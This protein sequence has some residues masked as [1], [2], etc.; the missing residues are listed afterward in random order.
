MMRSTLGAPLG[1]TI[2]GGHQGLESLA[3]FLMMPP[4]FGAGAGSW[5]PGIVVVALAVPSSPVTC[6]AFAEA[7]ASTNAAT[8][9][10]VSGAPWMQDFAVRGRCIAVLSIEGACSRARIGMRRG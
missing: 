2:R 9:V 10:A 7:L 3:S 6:C 5:F 8:R 1:G 4:N